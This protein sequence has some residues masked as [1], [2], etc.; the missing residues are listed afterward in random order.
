MMT[1]DNGSSIN[2]NLIIKIVIGIVIVGLCY[3]GY[4]WIDNKANANAKA[5]QAQ[6]D[7]LTKTNG[8]LVVQLAKAKNDY[9]EMKANPVEKTTIQYVEKTS[10]DDGD[11]EVNQKVPKVVVNAGDGN[12]YEYTPDAK[13]SSTIKDGKM[14]M[15][16]ENSVNIDIEKITD[17]RFKDRV[18]AL[19]SKHKLELKERDEQID[20]IN[21]KWKMARRQ[22]DFYASVAVVEGGVM[23]VKNW[24]M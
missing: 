7:S 19:E 11:F 15:T 17:A 12:R 13:T 3:G 16:T 10:K 5:L 20:T 1:S 6:I 14:V 8:D 23:L 2:Y 18:E 21:R 9:M 24:K 22:R 4:R